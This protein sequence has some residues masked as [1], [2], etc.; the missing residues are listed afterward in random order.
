MKLNFCSLSSGSSGNCYYL[1]NE[2]HG[3]LIDAGISATSIRKFLKNMDI[4]MQTIMGVLISHNHTDH[5]K[6]LE[7]LTRKNNLPAFTTNKIWQSILSPRNNISRDCI[8]EIPLMQKFH[9]A[10]FD[11]E[12]FPVCH[13]APETIGFH[14]CAGEKKI[15]IATDLGH[16]CQTAAPY[17]KA[18]NLL[19]IES[20][21]D[22]QM[23]VNGS[24]PHFLKA[25]IQSDHGHLGNHQ[26]SAFLAD[27]IGENL[28]NICL[29]H[30]SINNNT[31]ELVLQSLQQTFAERGIALNC[32][33]QISILNRN[34]PTDMIKL[35]E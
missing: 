23:L 22:E 28:S 27:N 5:I 7:V 18:A 2:F 25:R 21:Y 8:R 32:N 9:L 1:G 24:Y 12:A 34:M 10:G 17:I 16:I 19:V 15:T 11:I 26:T 31:P 13:D 33:H 20:N 30:L 29:A 14:I 35:G 4:S 6:G 3:I